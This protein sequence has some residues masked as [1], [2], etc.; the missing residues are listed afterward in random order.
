MGHS[1]AAIAIIHSVEN[2]SMQMIK[3]L[4]KLSYSRAEFGAARF[5]MFLAQSEYH[6]SFFSNIRL[7]NEQF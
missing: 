4:S 6:E 7:T 2:I 1:T 3:L 5:K